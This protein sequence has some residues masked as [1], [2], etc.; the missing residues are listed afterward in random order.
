MPSFETV[1]MPMTFSFQLSS[2]G[3]SKQ[4]PRI[5]LCQPGGASFCCCYMPHISPGVQG[6]LGVCCTL[7]SGCA[8]SL[9]GK[10]MHRGVSIRTSGTRGSG[11]WCNLLTDTDM[12]WF[13]CVHSPNLL[14][15]SI[16]IYMASPNASYMVFVTSCL[17]VQTSESNRG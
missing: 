3:A 13:R 5:G 17:A 10:V 1:Q 14:V 12:A 4:E 15:M 9:R 7:L 8:T 2:V 11:S 6:Q 16:Q